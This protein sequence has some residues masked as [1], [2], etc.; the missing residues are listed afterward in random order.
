MRSTIL[1][2][3]EEETWARPKDVE[4]GARVA[5]DLDLGL[6]GP[7]RV[8]GLVEQIAHHGCLRLI[9]G[10]A[11]IADRQVVVNAHMTFDEAR[12]LPIVTRAVV[13]LEDEDVATT[14]CAT[15]AFASALVVGMGE[16]RADRVAQRLGVARLGSADAVGEPTFFHVASCRTA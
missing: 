3:F 14:R 11:H 6:D 5:P 15:V 4:P 13:T 1:F 8:E 9:T 10:R 7:K 16:G 2:A 12:D